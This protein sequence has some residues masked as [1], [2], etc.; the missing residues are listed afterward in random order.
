MFTSA[1]NLVTAQMK[2]LS[3]IAPSALY[4]PGTGAYAPNLL[5]NGPQKQAVLEYISA[6]R[7]RGLPVDQTTL[8][9]W[10][11]PAILIDALRKFGTNATAEQLRSYVAAYKGPGIV[12]DYDF[13][14]YPQR[15]LN[16][17]SV[18]I[19]RWDQAHQTWAGASLLGGQPVK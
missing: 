8:N 9:G 5:R 19:V 12:G 2:T 6:M 16:A 1:A 4:I 11:E 14:Q 17:S 18:L 13:P 7:A 3:S 10:D 15:G